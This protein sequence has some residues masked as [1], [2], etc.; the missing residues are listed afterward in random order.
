MGALTCGGELAARCMLAE[1]PLECLALALGISGKP[2]V[3]PD[4]DDPGPR[5]LCPEHARMC[6]SD[7]AVKHA[8]PSD[9]RRAPP[10]GCVTTTHDQ[11]GRQDLLSLLECHATTNVTASTS[12]WGRS[13]QHSAYLARP[14]HPPRTDTPADCPA[15]LTTLLH[16]GPHLAAL[17]ASAPPCGY[18]R[19]ECQWT[20]RR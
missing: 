4:S 12:E 7:R 17:R 8:E 9:A 3:L 6:G 16:A 13:P 15:R 2:G 11:A 10:P 19:C 1:P 20:A 14:T 18:T 5:T